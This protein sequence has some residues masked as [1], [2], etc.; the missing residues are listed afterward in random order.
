MSDPSG[1]PAPGAGVSIRAARPDD[2]ET[3]APLVRDIFI[4]TFGPSNKPENI[5]AYVREAFAVEHV[6]AELEDP[7]TIALVADV[8]GQAAGFARMETGAAPEGIAGASP[9]ELVRLYV[10]ATYHGT[11]VAA[12]LM[13]ACI[14]AAK[15]R[16]CDVMWLGVWEH[17][18]RAQAFYRKWGFE[19][20]GEHVFQ[21]GDEAQ[22]DFLFQRP[23]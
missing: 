11:G 6:R 12:T 17:N 21:L 16:G 3:V 22:T 15:A 1:Q 7:S 19:R 8:D 23:L 4:E 18:P 2:A 9:V 10:R 14:D 20:A 5:D 13:Q